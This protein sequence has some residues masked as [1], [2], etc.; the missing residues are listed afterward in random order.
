VE[1][2]RVRAGFLIRRGWRAT[3]LLALL[4]G[5]AAGVAMAGWALGRRASTAFERFLTYA[6][7]PELLVSFCPPE[8]ETIDEAALFECILYDA[9]DEQ[10]RAS[11][12]PEVDAAARIKYSGAVAARQ[13]RPDRTWITAVVAQ[14]DDS[15]DTVDGRHI[16]VEGRRARADALEV[17]VN[18]R[19]RDNTDVA[20][21]EELMLSLWS[22][23]E[24]GQFAI[25]GGRFTGPQARVRVVGVVRPLR[26]LTAATGTAFA[27]IDEVRIYGGPA[28][29]S[30]TTDAAGFGGVAVNAR[31]D[32]VAAASAAIRREFDGQ[33]YQLAPAMET[34]DLDPISE[35]IRYEARGVLA[36]A[37]VAGVAAI[38]FAGQAVARQSRREWADGD[39]LR[40]IGMS[41]REAITSAAM[42]GAVTA[43]LAAVVAV[44]T[45]IALSAI[46]AFGVT[47][48]AEVDPG[49][50]VDG[51]VLVVGSVLVVGAVVVATSFPVALQFGRSSAGAD[52]TRRRRL[53][54]LRSGLPP[55]VAAGVG[56]ARTGGRRAGGLALGTALA[57]TAL[58]V[59][60]VVAAVGVTASL[61]HLE[62]TPEQ[63]G[64]PWDLSFSAESEDMYAAAAD[65]F[66]GHPDVDSMAGI[67]G[68]DVRIGEEVVW[69]Q[70]F[71]PING[72]DGLVAPVITSGR[73]PAAVDEIALGSTTMEDLDLSLGD[74]IEVRPTTTRQFSQTMRVVGTTIVNDTYENSPGRGG[75]VTPAWLERVSPESIDPDPVVIRLSPGADIA[76]FR[77]A[78]DEVVPDGVLGPV[79]QGAIRNVVRVSAIPL[80]LAALV[81]AL[82]VA[83]LAHA[84]I[85][86][87]RRHRSQL[88][89]LKSLGFRRGQVRAAVVWHATAL[90]MLAVLIGAPLG[91]IVGRWG[92]R[93]VADQIGVVSPPV[94]PLVPLVLA[95]A[96]AL[97]VANLV[98]VFPGWRAARIP[99][100]RALRVE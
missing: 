32:D 99:T 93:L 54:T 96:G 73:A 42:R 3:L 89:V 60:S 40:A 95:I 80:V 14:A 36:F 85:L 90:A 68:S 77:A 20:V 49:P 84:L 41:D 46:G 2:I 62:S 16:V 1:V 52:A 81:A 51:V 17:V 31:D 98:A 69:V 27:Q 29:A 56:M 79:Q 78:L 21:G 19:F 75:V 66:K 97:V 76:A 4:T 10:R 87:V 48:R 58:A 57:G 6:D 43:A 91:I 35:A 37:A 65:V 67:I 47:R 28:L 23:D 45:S 70:A 8:L 18:E 55:A 59:A 33:Q 39:S 53:G 34:D 72:V 63:F 11:A 88:A 71:A 50:V 7:E 64:A 30:A 24:L 22:Q 9:V 92:W 38:A 86:S 15:I 5:L 61:G 26:D 44:G 82:A 100:A 13:E 12:L 25:E 74:T 94:T 83:S